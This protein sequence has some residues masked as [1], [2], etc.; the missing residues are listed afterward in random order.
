MEPLFQ[1]VKCA[2]QKQLPAHAYKM[3]I[4]PIEWGG[5][6]DDQLV[7]TVPNAYLKKRVLDQFADLILTEWE[8][9]SGKAMKLQVEVKKN[10]EKAKSDPTEQAP[11]RPVQLNLPNMQL[12]PFSGRLLRRDFTFDQFVVGTNNDFAFS[13]ALA[14]ASRIR[15]EQH[16]LM[17]LSQTGMGKSHLSQAVGHHILRERP[18]ERVFYMTA[19]DFT[20]EM[21]QA[22]RQD[23]IDKFKKKYRDQCDTLLLEDVHFLSGKSRTQDEL[24][25]TLDY[26]SDT[27]KKIIFSSCFAP[28]EIPKISEQLRSRLSSGLITR[29]EAPSF[30]TRVRI[31]EKKAMAKRVDLPTEVIRYLASELTENVRQLES[32]LIGVSAKSSLLGKKIDLN[33]AES[34]VKHIVTQHKAITIDT[35]KELV[36]K[37]FDIT[38]KDITSKSRKQQ[39][40]RPRQIAMYLSRKFTDA[41][42]Q[43]IG[44]SFNRYHAT[45]LHAIHTVETGIKENSVL[46][47]QV[48]YLSDKLERG[49]F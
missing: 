11:K 31:L 16:A 48:N 14:H 27:G 5:T 18:Q 13:A 19:E 9:A 46:K 12:K 41:P 25:A 26:L 43:A 32:G 36:C 45:V 34:V 33:L 38:A 40:A 39:V 30:R 6:D 21:V 49:T 28:V 15:T 10:K 42:L 7:I 4:D 35:I 3:W 20:N 47:H 22:L 8:I 1:K 29:I 37:Q 17:L 24:S 2:C 23:D 44:K